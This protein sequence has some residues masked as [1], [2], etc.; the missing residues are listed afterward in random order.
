MDTSGAVQ[1]ADIGDMLSAISDSLVDFR[2]TQDIP[3]D[4]APGLNQSIEQISQ[5][6]QYMYAHSAAMVLDNV[7]DSLTQLKDITGQI[8]ANIKNL[9][10]VQKGINVAVSVVAVG[11]AIIELSPDNIASSVGGLINAWNS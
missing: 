6:S 1:A 8:N 11:S 4:L 7:Q 9:Q 5:Y 10:N 2:N 3:D